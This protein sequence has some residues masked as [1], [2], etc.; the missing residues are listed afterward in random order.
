MANCPSTR[1]TVISQ[2]SAQMITVLLVN[3]IFPY[4]TENE[5]KKWNICTV[6]ILLHIES[7]SLC[8]ITSM[9]CEQQ[10]NFDSYFRLP[11]VK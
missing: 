3:T 7:K 9:S 1:S 2:V 10:L 4:V 8:S 11:L 5:N 6:I